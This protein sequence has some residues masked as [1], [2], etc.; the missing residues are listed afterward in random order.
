MKCEAIKD[1][2]LTVKK[3]SIVE[4]EPFQFELCRHSLKP[5]ESKNTKK[6]K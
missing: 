3:G 4:V 5:I 2:N 6:G 1:V